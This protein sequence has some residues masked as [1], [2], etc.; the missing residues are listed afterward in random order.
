MNIVLLLCGILFVIFGILDLCLKGPTVKKI[1]K[2]IKEDRQ[3]EWDE[4]TRKMG[5]CKFI[6]AAD[7][8]LLGISGFL[9]MP[10]MESVYMKILAAGI[11]LLPVSVFFTFYIWFDYT[12]KLKE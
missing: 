10:E 7:L 6:F 1:K 2:Q 9:N 5:F 12:G 4:C 11:I 8:F 3:N